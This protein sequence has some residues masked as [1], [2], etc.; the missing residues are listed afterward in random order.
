[1]T[2]ERVDD[3]RPIPD[4]TILTTQ[5][6]LREVGSLRDIIEA[7]QAGVDKEIGLINGRL[8][9]RQN[10]IKEEVTH[11]QHL[12]DEKF[13]SIVVQF[14]ERD[15]RTEQTSKDSK[16]AVD[17]ALQA[18]KEAVAEQNKS[19]SLAIYK[20]EMATAKQI[21]QIGVTIQAMATNLNDKIDDMKSRITVTEGKGAG[22]AS[23][24]GWIVGAVGVVAAI[25]AIVGNIK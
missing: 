8:D 10:A 4:P 11:L 1:M 12:Q 16:V 2:A 20:S 18:A 19:S 21:D 24:W 25:I 7:R 9:G 6:L 23:L 14:A 3:I 5:Q 17:A 22:M 15:T 13:H